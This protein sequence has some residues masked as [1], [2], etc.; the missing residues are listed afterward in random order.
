MLA[1]KFY[2]QLYHS[3]WKT[4]ELKHTVKK[5][6]HCLFHTFIHPCWEKFFLNCKVNSRGTSIPQLVEVSRPIIKRQMLGEIIF[7]F[8]SFTRCSDFKGNW[9]PCRLRHD[10]RTS[11][12]GT[13]ADSHTEAHPRA[14]PRAGGPRCPAQGS[15]P[16]Q[17]RARRTAGLGT[18]SHSS[19]GREGKRG[20]PLHGEVATVGRGLSKACADWRRASPQRIR[21]AVVFRRVARVKR[22]ARRGGGR[23]AVVGAGPCWWRSCSGEAGGAPSWVSLRLA[24]GSVTVSGARGGF[25]GRRP[26]PAAD[27]GDR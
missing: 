10:V 7:T 21:P 26:R 14:E 5:I 23:G 13:A 2:F 4:P 9:E 11:T 19:A 16:Q 22:P 8:A 12:P 27:A 25:Q 1:C 17:T 24:Q 6:P 18:G 3:I 20:G 15:D